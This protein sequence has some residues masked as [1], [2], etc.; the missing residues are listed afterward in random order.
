MAGTDTRPMATMPHE[1][2]AWLLLDGSDAPP[3][4]LTP[5][6]LWY[7]LLWIV[8]GNPIIDHLTRTSSRDGNDPSVAL[9]ASDVNALVSF[10]RSVEFFEV[11]E[12]FLAFHLKKLAFA[13]CHKFATLP[14]PTYFE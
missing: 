10:L 7:L 13:R 1:D 2:Q 14:G 12:E 3:P 4:A 8:R 5:L 9:L 6:R 11:V